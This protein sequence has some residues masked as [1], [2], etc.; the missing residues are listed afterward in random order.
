MKKSLEVLTELQK[1]DT[2]I[3]KLQKEAE[4]LPKALN[5][6][7]K[8]CDS[9]NES[10]EEL[11]Q[12]L[13]DN[14]KN[15]K[16]LELDM[17]E[18]NNEINKYENQLLSVKTNKEYKAL[19]SEISYRKEQ[20]AEIEEK[21]IELMEDESNLKEEKKKLE[22][23]YEKDKQK[24]E[25]QKKKIEKDIDEIEKKIKDLKQKKDKLAKD[26]PLQLYRRYNRLIKHKNGR[27]LA[28]IEDGVCS[29][30]HFKIRPQIILE[31]TK[32]DSIITCENCSRIFIPNN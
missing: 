26:I 10:I 23:L 14:Y 12:K 6:L 3:I 31:V 27:A 16:N 13:E 1:L 20:N 18:N 28:T 4:R 11:S 9:Q 2:K 5:K 25:D 19:N 30:C 22:D 7:Q 15:Q 8:Q 29:G 21:L 17:A 32:G 24:L